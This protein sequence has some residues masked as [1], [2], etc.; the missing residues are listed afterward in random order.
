MENS[1]NSKKVLIIGLKKSG[2]SCFIN[3]LA[4]SLLIGYADK[5]RYLIAEPDSNEKI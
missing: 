4:N 3:A 1:K 2:K 5:Y